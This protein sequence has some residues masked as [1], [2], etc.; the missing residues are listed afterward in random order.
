[1]YP[2]RTVYAAK[3]EDE[4]GSDY[5]DVDAPTIEPQYAYLPDSRILG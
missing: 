4:E 2:P 5:E 1:M 3:A